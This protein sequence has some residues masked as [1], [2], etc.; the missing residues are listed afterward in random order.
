VLLLYIWLLGFDNQFVA[1]KLQKEIIFY[2]VLSF[3][4]A[5]SANIRLKNSQ[6]KQIVFTKQSD[7]ILLCLVSYIVK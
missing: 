5:E 2:L 7:F 1:R 6:N 4:I 3:V